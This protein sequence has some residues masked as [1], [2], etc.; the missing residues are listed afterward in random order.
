MYINSKDFAVLI[1]V[2]KGTTAVYDC[3][4]SV[5][6][7][8]PRDVE[9]FCVLHNPNLDLIQFIEN[10]PQ[11]NRVKVLR[12]YV[13][14]LS[15]VL[16]FGL[17][18]IQKRWIFRMDSDDLW[19]SNRFI[20][21]T[22]FLNRHPDAWVVSGGAFVKDKIRNIEYSLYNDTELNINRNALFQ[23]CPI[24]HPTTLYS[25]EKILGIG[26]YNTLYRAAEDYELWSRVISVGQIYR[27]PELLIE[28][29]VDI[30]SQSFLM[31]E[32]Q[33]Q[34]SEHIVFTMKVRT[35]RIPTCSLSHPVGSSI[36]CY[37]LKKVSDAIEF[38]KRQSN[39]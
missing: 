36:Y 12:A 37:L 29:N 7:D 17:E 32:I 2:H 6:S 34:E 11:R 35:L 14:N 24:I 3:L 26:G 31:K 28:Y 4:D 33:E 27:Q 8:V 1:P 9:I 18:N 15:Q 21:Q 39:R 19:L 13:K 20:T 22:N 16:N 5:I 38:F 10:Y 25:R 30:L 23:G